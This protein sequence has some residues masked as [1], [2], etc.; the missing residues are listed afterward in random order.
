MTLYAKS[1]CSRIAKNIIW[2]VWMLRRLLFLL[3][4]VDAE[5]GVAYLGSLARQC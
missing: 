3:L 4:G 2:Q 1:N 5:I